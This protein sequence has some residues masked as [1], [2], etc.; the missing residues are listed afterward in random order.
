MWKRHSALLVPL[1][2]LTS[3]SVPWTWIKKHQKEFNAIKKIILRKTLLSYL[4]FNELFDIHTNASKLQLGAVS[5]QNCNQ[6]F[7]S[8]KLNPA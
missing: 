5:S 4:N 8:R 2:E 3:D 7:Y 1:T 6:M